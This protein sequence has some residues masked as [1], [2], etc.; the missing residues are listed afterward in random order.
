[1]DRD[2]FS[3]KFVIYDVYNIYLYSL[4]DTKSNRRKVHDQVS[5][6]FAQQQHVANNTNGFAFQSLCDLT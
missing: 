1:M 4:P 6:L 2:I 3:M 5:V